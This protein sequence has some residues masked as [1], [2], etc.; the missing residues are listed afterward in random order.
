MIIMPRFFVDQQPQDGV[1]TLTGENAHHAGRV[2]RLRVGEGVT[3]CDG[4]GMDFDCTV[5]AVEKIVLSDLRRVF[6]MAKE[7]EKELLSLLQSNAEKESRKQLAAQKLEKE[8]A[9][10]RGQ[11]LDNIIRNLYEDKVNGTLSDE[12][13][14]KLSIEY[15]QEQAALTERIR[16]LQEVLSKAKEQSDNVSRFMRLIRKY[17]EIETLTPEIVRE[18]IEK[19]IVHERQKIDGKRVQAV[20]IIYNCVG[21]IPTLTESDTAA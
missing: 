12:R 8:T 1:L 18:F 21:V 6:A 3:L 15:E 9:E 10:R 11:A 14:R 2:L 13:F 17:T 4:A 20:E 5:E 19:V 16:K 7:R